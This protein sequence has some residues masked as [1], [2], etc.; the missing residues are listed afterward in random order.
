MQGK[1]DRQ[2]EPALVAQTIGL[3]ATHPVRARRGLSAG[4]GR[5]PAGPVALRSEPIGAH[6]VMGH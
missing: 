1:T 6:E 2:D 5:E 3:G 4:Q